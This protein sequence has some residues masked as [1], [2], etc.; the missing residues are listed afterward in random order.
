MGKQHPR[1]DVIGVP[2]Y[3][4]VE[5]RNDLDARFESSHILGGGARE[6]GQVQGERAIVR[7]GFEPE[8]Q[9][10]VGNP[11][12]VPASREPTDGIETVLARDPEREQADRQCIEVLRVLRVRPQLGQGSVLERGQLVLAPG[13]LDFL[14]VRQR[15]VQLVDRPEGEGSPPRRNHRDRAFRIGG[16][17]GGVPLDDLD[18]GSIG[19]P[20]DDR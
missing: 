17:E 13:V 8:R 2:A 15:R 18:P 14:V 9:Q 5:H 20:L 10:I 6:G 16:K 19:R 3:E 11:A 12:G 1:G 4:C 7:E